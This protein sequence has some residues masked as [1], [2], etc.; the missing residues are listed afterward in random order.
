MLDWW[1]DKIWEYY[2]GSEGSGMCVISPQE[3]RSHPGSVGRALM[4]IPHVIDEDGNELPVGETGEIWFESNSTYEYHNDPEKTRASIND[5]GWSTLGDVGHVDADGFVYLTD[6]V[7]NMIISGGVN[8]YPQE[9]ENLLW[10][11]PAIADVAVIGVP[12]D[13]MGESVKAFV[14]LQPGFL[15]SDAMASELIALCR[16]QLA[17]FKCPRSVEFVDALPRL[18]SGKLLKR[19][20][21]AN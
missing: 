20:L 6:R 15:A 10:M 8:I 4:G 14:Q 2:S 3:W 1:G 12:D 19:H 17:A 16:G 5:R 13:D 18:P 9:V 11:H 7:S 21:Q